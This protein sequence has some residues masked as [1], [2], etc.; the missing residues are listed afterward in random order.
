MGAVAGVPRAGMQTTAW[1]IDLLGWNAKWV[2]GYPGT[3]DLFVALERGEI[4]MTA[5]G[6]LF[7][8][9]KLVQGGK[10]KVLNQTGTLT[11]GKM[12]PR[13]EFSDAPVFT[14]ELQGKLPAGVQQKAFNYWFSLVVLDKWL[15]L[16]QDTPAPILKAYRD[17]F[18]KMTKDPEFLERGR[19]ISEDFEAQAGPDVDALLKTL[20]DTTPEALDYIKN[21]LKTQGVG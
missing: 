5:S 1:G 14:N 2:V 20:G 12:V 17:A 15:A 21:M 18:D 7:Q 19:K 10:V 6:N 9:A 3:N 13:P 4:D 8:V 16:P 11:A